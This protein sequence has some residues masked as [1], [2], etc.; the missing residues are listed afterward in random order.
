MPHPSRSER[1]ARRVLSEQR[2]LRLPI[3]VF[4]IAKKHAVVLKQHMRSEISG[5]LVPL[6]ETVSGKRWAIIV[7]KDHSSVRQRFTCAHELGHLLLHGYKTAHA[8]R[9]F[10]VR[11]RNAKSADGSVFEEIEAN[12]F[13]AELLMPTDIVMQRIQ[14]ANLEYVSQ[15]D[16]DDEVIDDLAQAFGVSKQA[17][18]IRLANIIA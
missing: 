6:E 9:G 2:K 11:F 4:S 12:R 17:F 7:N 15:L 13:A 3:D 1:E 14:E 10:K 8:D 18:S 16:E 5:M